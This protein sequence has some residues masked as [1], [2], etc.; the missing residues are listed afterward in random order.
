MDRARTLALEAIQFAPILTLAS[1]FVVSGEVDL[2]RASTLFIVAAAE[3][4]V[5]SAVVALLRGRFNTILIGTNVWLIMGAAA[6][7][8]PITPLADILG[9]MQATALFVCVLFV[10]LG[11]SWWS[12]HGFIGLDVR[13]AAARLTGSR[14]LILLTF[15][16]MLWSQ[17]FAHDIRLGGGFPF[18]MLNVSRRLLG[19]KLR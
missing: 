18:I 4:V 16:F 10:G 17:V 6:F 9:Q 15:L 5:I 3:A 7:G 11:L 8:V 2:E 1:T 14:Y 19:R 13:D 12:P